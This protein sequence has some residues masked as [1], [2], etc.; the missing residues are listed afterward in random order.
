MRLDTLAPALFL[1][2]LPLAP[3]RA[4]GAAPSGAVLQEE[5]PPEDKRP[6][7]AEL[8]ER[9]KAHAGARGA[10]DTEAIGAIDEL[11]GQFARSGP[12][13]RE[14]IAKAVS[15]CLEEKRAERGEEG[16]PAPNRL[17]LAAAVALG[18][19]G[20][21]SAGEL[22]GWIEHKRHRKDLELQRALILSLGKTR[23]ES[24]TKALV[25]L[26][27][28]KEAALVAAAAEALGEYG[29][30]PL[31]LRKD[32]F[33]A[34]LK[35]LMS[36]KGSMDADVTDNI[37]RERYQTF[38]AALMTTLGRLAHHEEPDPEA[39]QRWWN[40]NKRDDWGETG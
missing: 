7:V 20:P 13:D 15:K 39:W 26:L 9:L 12:K 25:D 18:R 19:M 30:A 38:A 21:E 35:T 28:N 34:C 37:A 5:T 32:L 36:A 22:E 3:A 6:E 2:V 14:R 17:Y 31:A 16:E 8:C 11:I 29:E 40:K 4:A 10:E 1:V 27:T 24:A 33:E 23:V